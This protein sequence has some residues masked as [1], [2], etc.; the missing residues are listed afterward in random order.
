MHLLRRASV[1]VGK[2]SFPIRGSQAPRPAGSSILRTAAVLLSAALLGFA[3]DARAENE[4][5]P[6]VADEEIVCSPSTYDPANGNIFYGPDETNEG[7]F[8]IR[9]TGDLSIDYDSSKPGDDFYFDAEQPE[10]RRLS[11][12]WVTPRDFESGYTGDIALVSDA[13]I[14]SSGRGISVGHYGASG[15][16]RMEILGGAVSTTGDGSYAIHNYHEGAGDTHLIVSGVTVH[17]D[18]S[19]AFATISGNYGAGNL[20]V[21]VR[22]TRLVT[23]GSSSDAV[24]ASKS[25]EGHLRITAQEFSA[26]TMG[27]FSG[28]FYVRHGGS[29]DL[30]IEARD[31]SISTTSRLGYGI[32]ALHSGAGDIRISARELSID[33]V[34]NDAKGVDARHGGAGALNVDADGLAIHTAGEDA[35]GVTA[36]HDGAGDVDVDVR[37]GKIVTTGL[38]AEGV[39]AQHEGAGRLE[40]FLRDLEVATAG[41]LAEGV[42][43]AHAG[44]GEGGLDASNVTIATTGAGADAVI[45]GHTG[46]GDFG[47]RVQGGS[48]TTEGAGSHGVYGVHNGA[49]ALRID[50]QESSIDATGERAEGVAS[51]H[52]GSGSVLIAVEGGTIRAAGSDANGVRMGRLNQSGVVGSAAPVGENG[53]RN[54]TVTVNGRVS[55]GSGEGAG[56]FLAG[57]GRVVIGPGGRIEAESGVAVRAAGD[58]PNL[59]IDVIGGRTVSELLGGVIRNKGGETVLAVNGVSLYESANGGRLDAWAPNGARDVALAQGF[60]GLDFSS[61]EGFVYRYTPRAAVYEALP[62]F[63]L[64]LD[65][66]GLSDKRVTSP[67]LPFWAR[68]SGGRGSYEPERSSVGAEYD[69]SR[70]AAEVGLV[71]LLEEG[72]TGSVSLRRMRGSADVKSP[73]GGGRMEADGYG[74]TF[75]F[76]LDWHDANYTRGSWSLAKYSADLSSSALGRLDSDVGANTN[77]LN[78]EVG[79]Y[80]AVNEKMRLTPR[81]WMARSAL[82]TDKFTDH[83]NSRVSAGDSTRFE[84][85]LGV[86][87]ETARARNWRGG[88]VSLRGSLDLAQTLDGGGTSVDVS[89]RTL[90]SESPKTRLFLGLGWAYRKDPFSIG[91]EISAGGLVSGDSEYSGRLTLGWEF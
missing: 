48:L 67:G 70:F 29:G 66:P 40:V 65:A 74:A 79:R 51:E 85:G 77:S 61:A 22:D 71:V 83:V 64:R 24:F 41:N 44:A 34:G 37:G 30:G 32:D 23:A 81:A 46:E 69:F 84:G 9:L 59:R 1:R 35:E 78:F 38:Q 3:S 42:F 88:V 76:S 25:G 28:G 49:G 36:T 15:D 56:V 19:S 31:G 91:A 57:G 21:D 2:R 7:D 82:K 72:A 26:E 60:T 80:I 43:A 20:N 16:L 55:G 73:A 62:G 87:A 52:G 17:T 10:N 50:L 89:G 5:G 47:I 27:V 4:C 14:T 18:G 8:S 45:A 63:L 12:V 90:K 13:D 58:A 6:P 68:I 75:G 39:F 33:T 11:A 53:Y 86:V 54:Q